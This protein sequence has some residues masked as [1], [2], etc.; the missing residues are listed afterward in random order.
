MV[1]SDFLS[2]QRNANSN[3]HEIIPISFN[4]YK[5]LNDN[6]YNIERNL[7]QTRSQAKSSGIKLPEVH[8]VGNNLDPNIKPEKQLA[9]SK[10]GSVERLCTG[11]GRAGLRRNKPDPINQIINQPSDLSQKIP[12]RTKIETGKT[13]QAHSRDLK[14]SIN[15]AN[16]KITGNK[17]LIPDVP[18]HP[19][20]VYRPLPKPIRHDMSNQQGSQSSSSI[21]DINPNINLDFKENSPFQESIMS[22][23]FRDQTSHFS[24]T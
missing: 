23:H 10:Q 20:P 21:E 19:G 4:T 15:N 14:H 16:E 17:T 3:P 1:V 2:R 9:N 24:R 6:Y 7:I 8:G 13:N 12:G 5:I 18:F 22:K 11:Q